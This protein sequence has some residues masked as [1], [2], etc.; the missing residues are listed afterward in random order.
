MV[1]M[2][3]RIVSESDEYSRGRWKKSALIVIS[4]WSRDRSSVTAVTR[5]SRKSL[6]VPSAGTEE[7]ISSNWSITS[8]RWL[9]S[10][11]SVR[12]R[13]RSR[14]RSSEV[15]SSRRSGGSST[16]TLRRAR[17]SC[18]KGCDPGY[19]SVTSQVAPSI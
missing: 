13:T 19:M 15:R 9:P 16:A 10:D 14:P 7:K 18:S 2:P 4:T 1:T 6:R 17:A 5:L 12:F 8:I 11:G 3:G